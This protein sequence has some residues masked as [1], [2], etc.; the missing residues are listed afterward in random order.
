MKGEGLTDKQ[1][2]KELQKLYK[3]EKHKRAGHILEFKMLKHLNEGDP[4]KRRLMYNAGMTMKEMIKNTD[5][6][7]KKTFDEFF[8]DQSIRDHLDKIL[9]PMTERMNE[10]TK[11]VTMMRAQTSVNDEKIKEIFKRLEDM[12]VVTKRCVD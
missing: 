5:A 6:D 9:C 8:I 10:M 11:T 3:M 4:K 12:V 1:R 7:T 2:E